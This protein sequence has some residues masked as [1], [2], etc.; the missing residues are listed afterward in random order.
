V[1]KDID[2]IPV[3]DMDEVLARALVRECKP[4]A[5]KQP[6]KRAAVKEPVRQPS[7]AEAAEQP[8]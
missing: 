7:A 2:I 1:R 3:T 6:K 4:A 5:I 8:E